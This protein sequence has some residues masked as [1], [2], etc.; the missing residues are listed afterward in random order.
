MGSSYKSPTSTENA[1]ELLSG[2]GEMG[3]IIRS[4][5]WAATSLGPV[6]TWPQSLLTTLSILLSSQ[7]P[8][9]LWWGSDLIQFYNDAYRPSM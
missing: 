2:G 3:E 6:E 8:M 9:V 4:Y 7:Y 5:N 1:Y